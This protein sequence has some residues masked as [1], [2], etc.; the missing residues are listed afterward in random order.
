MSE[1]DKL[2]VVIDRL[3]DTRIVV[4][5]NYGA[6]HNRRRDSAMDAAESAVGRQIHPWAVPVCAR[7]RPDQGISRRLNLQRVS[8]RGK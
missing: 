5:P 8:P 6:K 2:T 3:D 4:E 7:R 1:H